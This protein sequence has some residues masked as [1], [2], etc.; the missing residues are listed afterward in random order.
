MIVLRS[1][2]AIATYI[3]GKLNSPL[4]IHSQSLDF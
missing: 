4:L 2:A 1:V 3:N